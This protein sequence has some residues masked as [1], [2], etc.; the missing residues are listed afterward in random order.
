MYIALC[1]ATSIDNLFLIVKYNRN[2]F[3]VV[4][5]SRLRE[6]R[7]ETINTDYVGCNSL[8]VSLLTT[9]YL[10]KH[11]ADISRARR[12]IEN[13]ILCLTESQIMNDTDVAEIKEQL[14]QFLWCKT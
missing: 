1:R 3:K 12:L 7:F 5:Y 8:T 6:N 2:V 14:F 9:R 10:K 11:A 4:E 13:N